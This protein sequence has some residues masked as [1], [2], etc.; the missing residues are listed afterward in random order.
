MVLWNLC[1]PWV[2]QARDRGASVDLGLA[3]FT[4]SACLAQGSRTY[5]PQASFYLFFFFFFFIF[6]YCLNHCVLLWAVGL[7]WRGL[8]RMCSPLAKSW[9]GVCRLGTG[10]VWE[11]RGQLLQLLDIRNPLA[12]PALLQL[13]PLLAARVTSW[14]PWGFF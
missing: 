9:L 12:P 7:V 13:L 1:L 2:L 11:H 3:L 6:L 10:T 14:G 8:F 4:K 5:I